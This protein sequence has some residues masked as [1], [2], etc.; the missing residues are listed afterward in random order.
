MREF[1]LDLPDYPWDTMAPYRATAEAHPDGLINLSIGTP[2]DPTPSVIRDALAGATD[3]HGYP[4]TH[5]TL[6]LRQAIVDWF[7]RRRG[8]PGLSTDQVMPT[9]GSKE[10]V[11]WLPFLLGLGEGDVVVRPTVA[12]PTYDIGA[13][14]AGATPVAADSLDELDEATRARVRLVW[15]NSPANPTGIVRDV[16]E[17]K[18]IVE[19]A[20]ALGAVVASDECYAEL[21]WGEWDA[22]RGGKPVPSVLDPRV[23][24]ESQDLVLAAY[25]LSKQSNFAGYRGA[26]IAG[27][28]GIMANL[29][30]SRKHAGMI[31]PAPVQVAMTA[32]LSDDAHVETQKDLYRARRE[33]L[34]PALE[35]FGL[36]VEHSE[37]GLYLWA[38]AGEDTWAT[39]QRFADK[40]IVIGPGVFYGTAGEGYVRIAL[41]G[42]D[43]DITRAAARL[44]E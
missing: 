4:T 41:T 43:D 33:T 9:I 32:A 22:A 12:Y 15:I 27:D 18:K 40:G 38:T 25:S 11:A 21:G 17:L 13:Q 10:L 24:G 2:V 44:S 26:F 39:V 42:S 31:V 29:V 8:V 6:T 19:D 37:A 14:L 34:L 5:G 7:D 3:A 35:R 23:C 20:R 30:N 36:T 28:A 16:D 1:G